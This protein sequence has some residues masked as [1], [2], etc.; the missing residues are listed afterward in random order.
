MGETAEDAVEREAREETGLRVAVEG[1]VGLFD[2]VDRD[3]R[4]NVSAAFLCEANGE[5]SGSN[6]VDEVAL[7]GPGE[8]PED[9]AFDHRGIVGEALKVKDEGDKFSRIED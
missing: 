9:M 3:P 8:L 2:A 4:G 1:F 7:F 6:E 5:P